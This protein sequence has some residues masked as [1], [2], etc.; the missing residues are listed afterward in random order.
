M[1]LGKYSI[2]VAALLCLVGKRNIMAFL[3]A[4]ESVAFYF[5]WF[6]IYY[7]YPFDV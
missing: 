6:T 2:L 1:S 3:S 4:L 7:D 5:V